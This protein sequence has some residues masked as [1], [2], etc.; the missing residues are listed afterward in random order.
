[1][2]ATE[3]MHLLALDEHWR[4][5]GRLDGGGEWRDIVSH[6]LHLDSQ[7]LVI[8]QRRADDPFPTPRWG[9]I[10]LSRT[11]SRRLRPMEMKL[12]DHV[13]HAGQRRFSFREA[14]LL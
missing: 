1:M 5:L 7:W 10:H 4:P 2:T 8:E 14:G 12:A 13:I 11:L 6:L 3:T 9:D